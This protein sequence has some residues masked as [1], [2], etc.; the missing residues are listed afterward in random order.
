LLHLA[1][2]APE[3][4]EAHGGAEF[5]SLRAL[6][7]RNVGTHW[8]CRTVTSWGGLSS[9]S[10]EQFRLALRDLLKFFLRPFYF[11]DGVLNA[12]ARLN[13]SPTSCAANPFVAII[14]LPKAI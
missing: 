1:L 8:P 10:R 2:V 13:A 7:L 3:A 12:M 4:G 14:A 9:C 11:L 5:P 6:M